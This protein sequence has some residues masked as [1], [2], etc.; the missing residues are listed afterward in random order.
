MTSFILAYIFYPLYKLV[1][2]GVKNSSFAAFLV[3]LIIVLLFTAPLIF[4]ANAVST[5]ARIN[6]VFIKK[7]L[8]TGSITGG[9]CIDSNFLCQVMNSFEDLLKDPQIKFQITNITGRVTDFFINSA[10]S[11]I[12][13]IPV[14]LLN[15]FIMVFII[16][17]LL[18]E[19]DS[20]AFRIKKLL[21]LKKV[22]KKGIFDQL[23]DVTYAVV[24]GHIVVAGIQA[25]LGMLAFWIFG[26]HSPILWG[27]VMFF[28]ALI[29]FWC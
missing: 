11:F 13:S 4:I 10:S 22:H 6:Y 15:F 5:E 26:V 21:P 7:I 2:K 12:F 1:K 19:G 29:P 28:F 14:F 18:K 3:S 16:F 25:G 17:Y 20:I 8:A 27:F 24:Y 23:N 9:E